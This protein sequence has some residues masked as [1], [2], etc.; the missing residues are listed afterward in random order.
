VLQK[1]ELSCE[2]DSENNLGGS[3]QTYIPTGLLFCSMSFPCSLRL[4]KG[5]RYGVGCC[6]AGALG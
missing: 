5:L 2:A 3:S 4:K 6:F 1:A